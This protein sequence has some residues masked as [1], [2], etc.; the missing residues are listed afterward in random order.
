MARLTPQDVLD[1]I[2][3]IESGRES[4]ASHPFASSPGDE[5]PH[6]IWGLGGAQPS[7]VGVTA[8]GLEFRTGEYWASGW[9]EL[10]ETDDP[11]VVEGVERNAAALRRSME[12]ATARQEERSAR[13][14]E[15]KTSTADLIIDFLEDPTADRFDQMLSG[16]AVWIDHRDDDDAVVAAISRTLG[17]GVLTATSDGARLTIAG[18]NGER[19]ITPE[20]RDVTLRTIAGVLAPEIE[21]RQWIDDK[22]ADTVGIVVLTEQ[23]RVAVV[24]ARSERALNARLRRVHGRSRIFG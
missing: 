19:T 6:L 17:R 1:L 20:S 3:D 7:A 5:C 13:E 9:R 24:A 14:D 4:A 10:E 8:R 23:E 11:W 15:K 2:R 21:L 12:A 22:P 18:P 16:T